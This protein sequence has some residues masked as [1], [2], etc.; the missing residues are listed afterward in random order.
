VLTKLLNNGT[1]KW[2]HLGSQTF[3]WHRVGKGLDD[4]TSARIHDT[5]RC[6]SDRPRRLHASRSPSP[7]PAASSESSFSGGGGRR[8]RRYTKSGGSG[9]KNKLK[10][11]TRKR[12]NKTKS[13]H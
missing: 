11:M 2:T 13:K 3:H 1:R 10:K 5:D 4:D 8:R 9:S 6:P 7:P 12:K